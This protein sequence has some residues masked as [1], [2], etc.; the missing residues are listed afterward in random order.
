MWI[1][2]PGIREKVSELAWASTDNPCRT[3]F[4]LALEADLDLQDAADL[5][6]SQLELST[7]TLRINRANGV[8]HATVLS[9]NL[10]DALATRLADDADQALL[11]VLN[12]PEGMARFL[13]FAESLLAQAGSSEMPYFDAEQPSGT[14]TGMTRDCF[15]P[16]QYLEISSDG[17][18]KPCCRFEKWAKSDIDKISRDEPSFRSL[19]EKL[20]SGKL[21]PTCKSCSIRKKISVQE[22]NEKLRKKAEQKKADDLHAPWKLKELRIDINEACNLRCSYCPVSMPGY[23][24]QPMSG[25]I[26]EKVLSLALLTPKGVKLHINGHGETT[27]HPSWVP[28]CRSLVAQGKRPLI[29]T[30]LAKNYSD[31]EIDL[32]SY[33]SVV[34]VSL[35]S[36]DE[37]MMQK[38]RKPARVGKIF[39]D[40]ARIRAAAI[41]DGRRPPVMSLSVG[42]Y[43][44]S[45]WALS[46]FV[47]QIVSMR[48]NEV[49]F[50]NLVKYEHDKLTRPLRD[51]S[52]Q[53]SDRAAA[54]LSNIRQRLD[55][56]GIAYVFAGD[57]DGPDGRDM[58]AN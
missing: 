38:I 6:S 45:I 5:K 10:T 21:S 48:M 9:K 29:I 20:I 4:L 32:L 50:W 12:D 18:H 39:E 23:D 25:D 30:N 19:R 11:P 2:Q 47:D 43:D 13:K 3:A 58:L 14:E 53:D 57:F 22:F 24:G 42:I 8:N 49:T 31:E 15:D 36:A 16:W 26:L 46:D 37:G 28:F 34:Q 40:I 54:I 55:A 7:R 44:P 27:F 35:D 51:L 41:H 1:F 52:A 33:F 17:A 56:A